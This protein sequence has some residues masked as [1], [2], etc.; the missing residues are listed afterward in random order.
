MTEFPWAAV[1]LNILL[2][3]IAVAA[4]M[5]VVMG[6]SI[7]AKNHSLI[8]IFWGPAFVVVAV[9]SYL[10][11]AGSVGDSTRRLVVLVLTAVWGLRLGLH[12]GRRNRG[13][14]EDPR[15][16]ALMRHQ[17]GSLVGYLVRKVYGLQ[18]LLVVVVSLPVQVAMYESAPLGLL[19]GVGIAVWLVGFV[20]E[21][22]GD[23]QLTRFKADPAN[24]GRIMDRGLWAWTRHPNYF[25]DAC[26]WVG[27]F[28]LALG[29]PVGLLTVVSP[30]VMTTL[31]V[32]YSGKALLEKGMRRKRGA[33]YDDYI[34]RTSGFF[35]RP[36]RRS[37]RTEGAS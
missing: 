6:V 28:L 1:G 30:I 26:I 35:P 22:V 15:Y 37:A 23:Q 8:D 20:F 24:E 10:A 3:I 25:G 32:S 19:G 17:T 34:E 36:P 29:S 4:L 9:V 18:G 12:I 2:S 11:S 7:R 21:A 31:L 16:T 13:H 5:A 27:L 33:A 14:G